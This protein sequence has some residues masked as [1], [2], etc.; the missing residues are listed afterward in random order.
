MAYVEDTEAPYSGADGPELLT[1]Q[2]ALKLLYLTYRT[3]RA[4]GRRLGF[5]RVQFVAANAGDGTSSVARDFALVAAMRAHDRVLLLDL[6]MPANDQ[7][8][9]LGQ[10]GLIEG[11]APIQRVELGLPVEGPAGA[12]E[13][14]ATAHT[15]L[16]FHRVRASSLYISER[17][18]AAGAGGNGEPPGMTQ[19]WDRMRAEFELVVV[20]SP[21]LSQSFDP[22]MI[23]NQ[24]D[25]VVLIVN[26]ESTRAPVA[27][28][29]RDRLM[30]V[31]GP[32]IG[33]VLNR[34]RYH[35]PGFL[36]RRL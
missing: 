12:P 34:R 22:V 26:A 14:G 27:R 30:E 19:F 24:M 15:W 36:Y 7:L 28:N 32:V 16:A 10:R 18:A 5:V 4:R 31:G 3:V 17:Q 20:D 1:I 23:A 29:L 11:P 25:A 2:E 21:A 33:C 13:S 9:Q 6:A 8:R 35:I